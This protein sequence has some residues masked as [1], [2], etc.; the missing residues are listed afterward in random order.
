MLFKYPLLVVIL[1]KR[2]SLETI[3]KAVS[4]F[5]TRWYL[6]RKE[7]EYWDI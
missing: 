4:D 6:N 3:L 1:S 2:L 5:R 7:F